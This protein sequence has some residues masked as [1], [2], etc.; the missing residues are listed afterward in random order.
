MFKGLAEKQEAEWLA[1]HGLSHWSIL[2]C[3]WEGIQGNGRGRG[4]SPSPSPLSPSS[5]DPVFTPRQTLLAP[6]SFPPT[7]CTQPSPLP[8]TSPVAGYKEM[9]L[10]K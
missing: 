6:R 1:S 9:N 10:A 2:G 7:E 8:N 5:A 4:A 3:P